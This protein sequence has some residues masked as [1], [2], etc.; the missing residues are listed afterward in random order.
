MYPA[1][2]N[3][4]AA[5]LHCMAWHVNTAVTP[6]NPVE[7][8]PHLPLQTSNS[9]LVPVWAPHSPLTAAQW[10]AAGPGPSLGMVPTHCSRSAMTPPEPCCSR[11]FPPSLLPHYRPATPCRRPCGPH[12]HPRRQ[13]HHVR[14]TRPLP[15][16]GGCRSLWP[17]RGCWHGIWRPEDSRDPQGAQRHV[18]YEHFCQQWGTCLCIICGEWGWG[19]GGS[20]R[21]KG[22]KYWC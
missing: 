13:H 4:G 7:L 9:L 6:R 17:G 18:Y 21:K 16:R 22:K 15:R 2:S 5:A 14:R 1:R 12:I 20:A 3:Y 8:V 19:G 10:M 11:P